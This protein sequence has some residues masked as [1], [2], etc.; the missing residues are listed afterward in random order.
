M[1]HSDTFDISLAQSM[2]YQIDFFGAGCRINNQFDRGG[3]CGLA[4]QPNAQGQ[5]RKHRRNEPIRAH[6]Q[7][8][9]SQQ[10]AAGLV[11]VAPGLPAN[12][13]AILTFFCRSLTN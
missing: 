10:P 11:E 12:G 1:S 4:Q 5:R 9:F 13:E 8:N 3:Q 7:K 6:L 2:F